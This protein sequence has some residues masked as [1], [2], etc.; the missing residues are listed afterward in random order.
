MSTEK[1][2]GIGGMPRSGKDSLAELFIQAGYYGVSFGDIVRKFTFERHK[3]KPDPISVANMTETSNWLRETYG[4]DVVLQEALKQFRERQQAGGSYKGM[5]LWSLRAPVE[6]EFVLA[7]KGEMIWVEASDEVR[8]ER[9]LKNLRKGELPTSLEEFKRQEAL[10]WKPQPGVP[11]EAQMDLS[12]VKSHATYTFV[13]NE[14][15]LDTFLGKAEKLIE[16]LS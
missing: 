16:T 4:P 15:D 12:Y 8:H 3:D 9:A 10:Q 13:N 7:H 6:V 1:I 2:V 11:V 5:V 14:D